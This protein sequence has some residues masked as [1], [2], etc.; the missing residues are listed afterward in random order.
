MNYMKKR[1]IKYYKNEL[2][3]DG[4]ALIIASSVASMA[5]T[6]SIKEK[7]VCQGQSD[8]IFILVC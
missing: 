6:F 2:L 3:S 1:Y 5:P 8:K 7:T 4:R